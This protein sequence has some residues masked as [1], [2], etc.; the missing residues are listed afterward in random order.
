[1][2]VRSDEQVVFA[3]H[4]LEPDECGPFGIGLGVCFDNGE[5]GVSAVTIGILGEDKPGAQG[6]GLHKQGYLVGLDMYDSVGTLPVDKTDFGPADRLGQG[7]RGG[8]CRP[9]QFKVVVDAR[10]A[11]AQKRR[12]SGDADWIGLTSSSSRSNWPDF[13]AASVSNL[14]MR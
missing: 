1:M 8:Y 9:F 5:L 11:A 14:L 12:S 3:G 7:I 10:E 4:R 13:L 6:S 2:A